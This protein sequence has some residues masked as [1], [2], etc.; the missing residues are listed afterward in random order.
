MPKNPNHIDKE[1]RCFAEM[2]LDAGASVEL[3]MAIRTAFYAGAVGMYDILMH[4]LPDDHT[5]EDAEFL[6]LEVEAEIE[7]YA[8]EDTVEV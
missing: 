5:E 7:E 1:W 8:V 3:H 4:S 6:L 2:F